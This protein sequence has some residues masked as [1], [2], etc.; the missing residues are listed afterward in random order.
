MNTAM[1]VTKY[2]ILGYFRLCKLHH[3]LQTDYISMTCSNQQCVCFV[4]LRLLPVF[5]SHYWNALL[6][7]LSSFVTARL[8]EYEE[9]R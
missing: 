5:K 4:C 8:S 7:E 1:I 6:V 3:S 2:R 9:D